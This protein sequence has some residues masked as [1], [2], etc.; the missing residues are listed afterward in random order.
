MVPVVYRCRQC[1][2]ILYV[3]WRVGQSSYGVPTPSEIMSYYG[4]VC[5]RCG[6]P[7]QRPSIRDVIV[8][9]GRELVEARIGLL[10]RL[11]EE[12]RRP[13]LLHLPVRPAGEVAADA[14]AGV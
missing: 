2:Y 1:G 3:F 4:G 5:P 12:Q 11:L 6:R 13:R 7:L 10:K 14:Q 9:A 8:V